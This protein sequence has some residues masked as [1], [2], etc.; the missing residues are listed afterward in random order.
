MTFARAIVKTACFQSM[1]SATRLEASVQEA[2]LWA[3]PTH[4]AVKL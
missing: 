2:R 4:S 3:M 1:P